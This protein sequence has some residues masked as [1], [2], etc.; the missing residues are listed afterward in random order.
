MAKKF[1]QS[2]KIRAVQKALSRTDGSGLEEF[3]LAMGVGYS[4]LQNWI[5]QS[6]NQELDSTTAD[7]NVMK[8]ERRPQDWSAEER[9]E[10][11]I[12]CAALDENSVAELCRQQ[13]IYPHHITQWKAD[14]SSGKP[15]AKPVEK[16]ADTKQLKSEIKQLKKELNRK[17]KALAET[18]AL[19]VLQKKLKVIWGCDED[20]SQ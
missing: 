11:I 12:R 16:Q 6:K 20:N 10:M 19:L 18:A 15:T 2:F 9:L 5:R 13:G 8:N 4:T 3:A 1:S 14:F 17:D 7:I